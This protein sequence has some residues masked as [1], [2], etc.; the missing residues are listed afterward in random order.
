MT[1]IK[2]AI[3][4]VLLAFILLI[5]NIVFVG[6]TTLKFT[7]NCPWPVTFHLFKCGDDGC[8][9]NCQHGIK[10]ENKHHD[11]VKVTNLKQGEEEEYDDSIDRGSYYCFLDSNGESTEIHDYDSSSRDYHISH[12]IG[13]ESLGSTGAHPHLY[14][15][16]HDERLANMTTSFIGIGLGNANVENDKNIT[17]YPAGHLIKLHYVDLQNFSLSFPSVNVNCQFYHSDTHG[18]IGFDCTGLRNIPVIRKITLAS[19]DSDSPIKVAYEMICTRSKLSQ[20]ACP[21][22][23]NSYHA[24]QLPNIFSN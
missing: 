18:Y 8:D 19:K 2:Y 6:A 21:W 15:C 4:S 7:N 16:G 10:Y 1:N 13:F 5:S 9:K 24:T 22:V 11:L 23:G 3:R 14:A 12:S 20:T 17:T